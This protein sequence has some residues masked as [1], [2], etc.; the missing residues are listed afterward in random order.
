MADKTTLYL[1][2]E[3]R[4]ELARL[5]KREGRPQAEIVREAESS[6]PGQG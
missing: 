6:G 2:E 3:M 1:S 5:A 4:Q